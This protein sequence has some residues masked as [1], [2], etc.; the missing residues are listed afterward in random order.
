MRRSLPR[1][2]RGSLLIVTMLLGALLIVALSSFVAL[3]TSSLKMASRSFYALEAM[4]MVESGLEEA[5]WS[6]NQARNGDAAAWSGWT[7]TGDSAK[8]TFSD[9][10]LGAN[11]TGSVKVYVDYYNPP[12]TVQPKVVAQATITLPNNQGTVSKTVEIK[13]R[14]RTYFAAGLVAKDGIKF[15]GTSAS[16]D[17]WISDDDNN[18]ATPA[19]AY[20][21]A[22]NKRDRGS[23]AGAS[24]TA[25]L[26]IGNADI[27][28]TAAVG[29]SSLSAIAVGPN[30]KVGTFTTANGVKDPTRV[31]TDF[32]T[33]LETVTNPTTGTTIAS[34][35]ST[36]GT[37]GT[38]TVWRVPQ[39]TSSFTVEGNVTLIITAASG[40]DAIALTSAGQG[41]TLAP[42]ATLSIYTAGDIRVTGNGI[43]NP[44]NDPASLQIWGT[45]T[46][47]VAQTI[48]VAGNGALKGV[49]YAP[50]GSIYI[51]GNGDVMG[52]VVGKEIDVTGN[53]SFHYDESLGA[54]SAN[55]PYGITK[56]RELVTA[57][58][59]DPY[60]THLAF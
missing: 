53:A 22:T 27:F 26:A 56:W 42:G 13:M 2:Q 58:D 7:I 52:A 8:R 34:V 41:I 11:A 19:V 17:S 29:G 31:A 60:T 38:T 14:R 4:N 48:R 55:T 32:T 3:N 47:T 46:S 50:N 20:D 12:T 33:N 18:T 44:N 40:V 49:I 28:G 9:F 21:A 25:T 15:S 39:V 37:A 59:R 1:S 51:N 6:F 45:S 10:V 30:G 23:I 54:W 35:G 43:L 5:V 36:L 24:V 57:T 16:V